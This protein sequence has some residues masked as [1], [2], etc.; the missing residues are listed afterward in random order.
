MLPIDVWHFKSQCS[1][2]RSGWFLCFMFFSSFLEIWHGNENSCFYNW[3]GKV[4]KH[5]V[6]LLSFIFSVNVDLF[7]HRKQFLEKYYFYCSSLSLSMSYVWRGKH[8]CKYR[9][10]TG[11][12]ESSKL[13]RMLCVSFNIFVFNVC[14]PTVPSLSLRC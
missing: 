8:I 11:E 9:H 7:H 4:I 6:C 1:Q 3:K 13:E 12:I 14:C 10:Y 5:N 2:L